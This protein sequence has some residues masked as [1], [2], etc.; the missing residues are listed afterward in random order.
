M[1]GD[2]VEKILSFN[3]KLKNAGSRGEFCLA[4]GFRNNILVISYSLN[5]SLFRNQCRSADSVRLKNQR[6]S[7]SVAARGPYFHVSLA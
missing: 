5:K 3:L 4:R 6:F 1:A 2:V 7:P